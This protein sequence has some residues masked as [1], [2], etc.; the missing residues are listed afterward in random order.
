M[1]IK[2]FYISLVI[3]LVGI[4]SVCPQKRVT[5]IALDFQVNKTLIDPA[6]GDNEGHLAEIRDFIHNLRGD[7]AVQI[8]EVSF[9]GAASPEGSYQLNRKLARKRLLA[10]EQFVRGQIDLPDSVVTYN[11]SY[12]PWHYLREQIAISDL[13]RKEEVLAILDEDSSLVDYHHVNTQI[14]RRVVR[15]RELDGGSVWRQLLDNYF[16]PMRNATAVFVT[17]RR[18]PVSKPVPVVLPDTVPVVPMP[19]QVVE[20]PQWR[21]SIYIKTNGIGWLMMVSNLAVEFDLARHWS[22]TLP[23]YYS[24]MNYFT[25]TL[26]FRTFTVQPELRYWFGENEG[27]FVGAHFGLGYYNYALNG[28]WRIQDHDRQTPAMGGGL[29]AGYRLPLGRSDHWKME[30]SIGG[31]VYPVHYDRFHNVNDGLLFDSKKTTFIGVDN[32]AV[33]LV[34]RF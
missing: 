9:C 29:S 3:L 6:F 27:W 18:L 7:S 26:K 34:Y 8:L 5:E 13:P 16:G 31:G 22:V 17:Y 20:A 30:F 4:L 24:A 28:D 19:E 14:D 23:I 10:L 15:L 33:S 32:A 25:R 12:I 21:R 1:R 2:R 11:D